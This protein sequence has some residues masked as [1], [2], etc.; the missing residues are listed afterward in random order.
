MLEKYTRPKLQ[1]WFDTV[2]RSPFIFHFSPDLITLCSLMTGFLSAW[3]MSQNHMIIALIFLWCSGLCDVLD[4]T[5]ARLK[6]R[7]TIY[8]AYFDLLTDR[9]VEA[10]IILG[11]A[12]RF[13]QYCLSYIIFLIALLLH[14]S[15]FLIVSGTQKNSGQKVIHFDHSIVERAEAFI[16]FS[17]MML[18]PSYIAIILIP[19]SIIIL[20]SAL[21]R[22]RRIYKYLKK[23]N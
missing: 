1:P 11:F 21:N 10:I 15:S 3:C 12:M 16:A 19:F 9:L 2:A 22:C 18:F 7:S 23:I 4:G 13:P 8:G 14:F 17:C 6:N 5:I 20:F